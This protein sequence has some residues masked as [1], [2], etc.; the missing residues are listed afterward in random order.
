MLIQDAEKTMVDKEKILERA[1]NKPRKKRTAPIMTAPDVRKTNFEQYMS[2]LTMEQ[3]VEEANRCL[4]CGC[5]AGCEICKDICKMFAW[6][7]SP[8]GK[9]FLDEDKCVACGMCIHLCPNGNI[10]MKQTGDE[11]LIS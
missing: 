1:G 10:E 11:N 6:D 5:G 9:V 4:S 2:T 8:E 3:A 7:M